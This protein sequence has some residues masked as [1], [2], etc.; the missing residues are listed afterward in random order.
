MLFGLHLFNPAVS[1]LT[2][3]LPSI[4]Y[5]RLQG[6]FHP[7]LAELVEH[8][9]GHPSHCPLFTSPH[10]CP[11]GPPGRRGPPPELSPLTPSRVAPPGVWEQVAPLCLPQGAGGHFSFPLPHCCGDSLYRDTGQERCLPLPK[12]QAG[13]QAASSCL[14]A[15]APAPSPGHGAGLKV[16]R[17][18]MT[19]RI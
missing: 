4:T 14:A 15:T 2:N 16:N 7:S 5:T 1:C 10:W 12:E 11:T 8:R 13:E 19:L 9:R 6:W 3:V 17:V 18:R